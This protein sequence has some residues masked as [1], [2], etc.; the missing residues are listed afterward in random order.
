M[1]AVCY[2]TITCTLALVLYLYLY[3]CLQF[4][5]G[6]GR[7]GPD[8][9]LSCFI[10]PLQHLPSSTAPHPPPTPPLANP[11]SRC[12]PHIQSSSPGTVSS[13][14]FQER[15]G[16]AQCRSGLVG[17]SS[18]CHPTV[19]LSPRTHSPASWRSSFVIRHSDGGQGEE[20]S[21]N[22]RFLFWGTG[23]GCGV[24]FRY[25]SGC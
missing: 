13:S 23:L 16:K 20:G 19:P 2:I 24:G 18:R 25:S 12:H 8:P 7:A 17:R 4:P 5:P 6:P 22:L 21:Y 1:C 3:L 10:H 9:A 11:R 15:E 14:T